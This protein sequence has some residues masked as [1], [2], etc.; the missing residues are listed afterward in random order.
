M[1]LIDE[2]YPGPWEIKDGKLYKGETLME[3]N[4]ELV[5]DFG[6]RTGDTVTIFNGDTRVSTN[7]KKEDGSRAVGTKISAEVGEKVLKQGIPHFG[8]ANVVG[9]INQ[10]AY[11]PI[12][13]AKG[14]IIGIW[15]VGVPNKPYEDSIQSFRE[16]IV[17]FAAAQ[18]VIAVIVI[19]VLVRRK[20]KPLIAV[21]RIAE[22]VAGGNLKVELT[23]YRSGDEIG[24]L[25]VAVN[26][27]ITSLQRMITDINENVLTSAD[28]V[29]VSSDS[30]ARSI[31]GVTQSYHEVVVSNQSMT[32]NA[33]A[34][35]E[36]VRESSQ[37]LL[38][39]SSLI[40]IA[41]AKATEAQQDSLR[42]LDVAEKGKETVVHTMECMESIQ[43]C[44]SDTE[45]QVAALQQYSKQ[46][47][48]IANTIT[49][50]ANS[51]NLLAL[52]ASIEAARAGE[53]GRG[54][55][56]VAG[57]VK[58]LAEQS[59][60]EAAEV[61]VL[62]KKITDCIELVVHTNERS[63][64]EVV[65]GAES[66]DAAGR[67]LAE[68]MAAVEGTVSN[69]E[70]VTDIT[71]EEVASSERI[72]QLINGVASSIESTMASAQQ[73]LKATE[74]ISDELQELAAGSEELTAMA[75]DLKATV[76][77]INV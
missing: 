2:I 67:A 36:A 42:T 71:N 60:K 44:S 56:V 70:A 64:N 55:A 21:T 31:E 53:S 6:S 18:L 52:N 74:Q 28:Q 39:L 72:I 12:K 77:K 22:E 3:G 62:I 66:A 75:T 63:R 76:G 35:N 10:A 65:K 57:E 9:K 24:R 23:P 25:S 16:G 26:G 37:V 4:D 69:I 43:V 29:A 11:E 59:N 14:E 49:E 40:Q 1:H 32:E 45:K 30:M 68:V 41:N 51:T 15:Y 50:I 54:F 73:V 27:M 47:E 5:D 13:N 38:E 34:G 61:N 20:V 19:W 8:E 48:I 33:M 46:I 17:V 58:K 7:V